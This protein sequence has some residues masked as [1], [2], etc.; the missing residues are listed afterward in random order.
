M[1]SA[2]P[3][4]DI[5][6][7]LLRSSCRSVSIALYLLSQFF[8]HPPKLLHILILVYVFVFRCGC[9]RRVDCRQLRERETEN[10]IKWSAALLAKTKN[11]KARQM[12]PLVRGEHVAV[13]CLH[14]S[15]FFHDGDVTAL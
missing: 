10:K 11:I 7:I 13:S 5:E 6:V 14:F 4:N 2:C 8:L 1:V 3:P 15:I 9:S 12:L